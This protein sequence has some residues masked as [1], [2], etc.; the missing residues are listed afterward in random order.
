MSTG[1]PASEKLAAEGPRNTEFTIPQKETR[2]SDS[3][4]ALSFLCDTPSLK[5]LGHPR[6]FLSAV[7]CASQILDMVLHVG[8]FE[9]FPDQ[10]Q[11][12][13][14]LADGSTLL[15]AVGDAPVRAAL[16]VKVEKVRVARDEHSLLGH[17]ELPVDFVIHADEIPFRR[18]ADIDSAPSQSRCNG[19]V[20][21]L[22][23]M[24][25]DRP[26]HWWRP[27]FRRVA[28]PTVDASGLPNPTRPACRVESRRGGPSSTTAR[29][30]RPPS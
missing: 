28:K 15:M 5:Q 18:R 27:V 14:Q 13:D 4:S 17:H 12:V 8:G 2:F 25:A 30:K 3:M 22:V 23:E 26:S 1:D 10:F 11:G 21:V 16:I 9:H 24:E 6:L 29:R 19:R 7:F 20:N